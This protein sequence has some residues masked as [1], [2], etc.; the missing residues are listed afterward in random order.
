MFIKRSVK[1]LLVHMHRVET[2]EDRYGDDKSGG[3]CALKV[4]R[5]ATDLC[6]CVP[7][8]CLLFEIV[9]RVTEKERAR[10]FILLTGVREM[11]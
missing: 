5:K 2:A 1:K 10:E 11:A 3:A 8:V 7:C 6:V 9:E 4:G